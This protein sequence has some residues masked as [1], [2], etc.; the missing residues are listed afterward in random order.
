MFIINKND[1]MATK[2]EDICYRSV[3]S[4]NAKKEMLRIED[5]ICDKAYYIGSEAKTKAIIKLK[6]EEYK[7]EHPE[8]LLWVIY[9][10][11]INYGE[12]NS[13][14]DVIKEY[15]CILTALRSNKKVYQIGETMVN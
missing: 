14:V 1:D 11:G 15:H 3:W 12:F 8:E 7:M 5:S 13:E 10:N 4:D 9:I 2:V 6:I